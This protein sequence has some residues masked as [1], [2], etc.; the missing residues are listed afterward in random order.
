[1]SAQSNA[2]TRKMS[3]RSVAT[4]GGRHGANPTR[5]RVKSIERKRMLRQFGLDAEN[6]GQRTA[7]NVKRAIKKRLKTREERAWK[8]D[9]A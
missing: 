4:T 8:S 1:M 7:A 3:R 6:H 9:Q 2:G 5:Q